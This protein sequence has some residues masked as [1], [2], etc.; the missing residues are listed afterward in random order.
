M[1]EFIGTIKLFAFNYAPK[2]WALCNGQLLPVAQNQELFSVIGTT[3][4]GDGRNTF[5]LPDL[6][7]RAP[8]HYGRTASSSYSMGQI[9]GA[10]NV[11]LSLSQM[12]L[13]NHTLAPG[14][15]PVTGTIDVNASLQ[16]SNQL[17]SNTTPEPGNVLS[18]GNEAAGT[19]GDVQIY[20]NNTPNTAIGG[21]SVTATPNNLSVNTAG[22]VTSNA[23]GNTPVPTMTPFLVMNYCI[24]IE[25]NCALHIQNDIKYSSIDFVNNKK[26]FLI[27]K[28]NNRFIKHFY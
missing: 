21:L 4:G 20:S 28:D 12:P 15:L 2:G 27:S 9:G 22:G 24:C 26:S 3:Y 13:H 18:K 6:R 16:V 14:N 8:V 19:G 25:G 5:A 17:A 10:E 1:N 23:G 11:V 7:G